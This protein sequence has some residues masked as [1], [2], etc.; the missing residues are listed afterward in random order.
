MNMSRCRIIIPVKTQIGVFKLA[1]T[2]LNKATNIT[3]K[4]SCQLDQLDTRSK[5]RNEMQN[6]KREFKENSRL[7]ND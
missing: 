7:N 3:E 1:S 2:Q 5:H 6:V 4:S